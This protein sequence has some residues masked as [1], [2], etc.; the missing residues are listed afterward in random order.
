MAAVT[1]TDV[2]KAYGPVEVLRNIN[3]D[4]DQGELVV[5]VGP[6]GCGK[7]TLLR[8]IAGLELIPLFASAPPPGL[9]AGP[10]PHGPD[11]C[12][13]TERGA[14]PALGVSE[15][16]SKDEWDEEQGVLTHW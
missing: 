2:S 5:F 15:L 16:V 13:S 12:E 1:L 11:P 9:Q 6:S 3:L 4:I 7:S 14:Q 10:P 8:M